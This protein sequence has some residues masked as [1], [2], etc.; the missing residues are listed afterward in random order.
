MADVSSEPSAWAEAEAE[1]APVGFV[2]LIVIQSTLSS[3]LSRTRPR[4]PA[5]MNVPARSKCP[6]EQRGETLVL[7]G[8]SLVYE[9]CRLKTEPVE[10]WRISRNDC[11]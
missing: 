6:A 4:R 10:Q 11:Y 5:K 2:G 7:V 3:Q 9:Y 8:P 1:A